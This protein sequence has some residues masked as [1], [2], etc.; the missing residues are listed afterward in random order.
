[1]FQGETASPAEWPFVVKERLC[2]F[3][4]YGKVQARTAHMWKG[5]SKTLENRKTFLINLPLKRMLNKPEHFIQKAFELSRVSTISV[6]LI[7]S[8]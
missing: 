2:V 8:V 4:G 1:M 5:F 6:F 7:P 3:C